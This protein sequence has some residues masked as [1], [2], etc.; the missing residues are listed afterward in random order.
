MHVPFGKIGVRTDESHMAPAS[1]TA[2][3]TSLTRFAY[4]LSVTSVTLALLHPLVPGASA[5]GGGGGKGGGFIVGLVGVRVVCV[6][7]CLCVCVCESV[8]VCV[9]VRECV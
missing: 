4:W 6:C 1:P 3:H 2:D 5:A 8:C 9:C 7:V